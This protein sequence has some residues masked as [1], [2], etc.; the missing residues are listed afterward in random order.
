MSNDTADE[1]VLL[2]QPRLIDFTGGTYLLSEHGLVV[3]EGADEGE[4]RL[5]AESLIA[6]LRGP[7]RTGWKISRGETESLAAAVGSSPVGHLS[8]IRL[9][10]TPNYVTHNQGYEISITDNGVE[11]VASSPAGIFYSTQTLIQIIRQAGRALPHLHIRDWPDFPNRGVMLDISRDK[12][13]TMDTLFSLVDLLGSWKIN[14]FQLYT[15]H[16]FAY[17][18]HPAV[19]SGASPVTAEEM[20]E[21]DRY[22]RERFIELV[23]NQNS[24]GHMRRWLVHKEYNHLAEC[25]Q[26]CDTSWGHFD[27][28]FSLAPADSGSIE[29]ISGLFDELLPNFR[30]SQINVGCDETV[31]LGQG[32]SKDLVARLGSGRVYLD[33][34]LK[35]YKEVKARDHTMQFWGDI[36]MEHPELVDEL[37][38]DLVALEWGYEANHPFDKNCALFADS[39]VPFYV[40]PGTSAWNSVA[41]RTSNALSNMS[42]AAESGL[43]H[44]AIGYLNTD[45]GDNGHWQPLPVSFLGYAYGAAVSWAVEANRDIA[46]QD[47]L[48][49]FAFLDPGGIAGVAAYDLGNVYESSQIQLPNS[50]VLFRV[51]QAEPDKISSLVCPNGET[52]Q[53]VKQFRTTLA[54]ID[55]ISSSLPE[56]RMQRVDADLVQGELSWVANMLRHACRR[57]IWALRR[58]QG[59]EDTVLGQR[60]VGEAKLLMAEHEAIWQARN[61]PGGF[62]DSQ[63]RL[64]RMA[65]AYGEA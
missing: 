24:F 56:S 55:G 28:P 13:P 61:R 21:L 44:G 65:K 12:V 17:K 16:T 4:F 36:V 9:R 64:A 23:P 35:I 58:G 49:T 46:V 5:A 18:N 8:T 6:A 43:K 57:A 48:N 7:N 31:D 38:R 37:P 32:R 52:D 29:L 34:L 47:T 3:I 45:W 20:Q 22:C 40:C 10:V 53:A 26:G 50:T 54:I 30:S 41:G 42:N 2:P 33:F 14:Q 59:E 25:P 39:K 11:A 63:T 27:E 15:E 19:W 51:L 60:L 62:A 1:F